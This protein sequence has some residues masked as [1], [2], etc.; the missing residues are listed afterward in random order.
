MGRRGWWG[1]AVVVV[2]AALGL[3]WWAG[4]KSVRL[5]PYDG[6]SALPGMRMQR[7]AG[8]REISGYTNPGALFWRR[9]V[10]AG[11]GY[12]FYQYASDG[13]ASGDYGAVPFFWYAD[14]TPVAM[15]WGGIMGGGGSLSAQDSAYGQSSLNTAVMIGLVRRGQDSV[16]VAV[17]RTPIEAAEKARAEQVLALVASRPMSVYHAYEFLKLVPELGRT[18]NAAIIKGVK[19]L[20]E[21]SEPLEELRAVV[22]SQADRST[23]N[24]RS[25]THTYTAANAPKAGTQ[26]DAL[27]SA[28]QYVLRQWTAAPPQAATV[29]AA[30]AAAG[31]RGLVIEKAVWFTPENPEFDI[32]QKIAARVSGGRLLINAISVKTLEVPGAPPSPGRLT[33]TFRINGEERTWT[34][35]TGAQLLLDASKPGP[36]R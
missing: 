19:R 10:V 3:W 27:R 17:V 32:T 18:T 25:Y 35:W 21:G 14:G 11:E 22:T 6:A 36:G 29:P 5:K 7:A 9:Y 26:A 15:D 13:A 4:G 16:E 2:L 23:W 31:E 1:V 24:Q 34:G 33:V 20:A 8:K 12:D 30:T 28:A